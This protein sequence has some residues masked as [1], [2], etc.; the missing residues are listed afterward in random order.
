M[1]Y[2]MWM[3]EGVCQTCRR[4]ETRFKEHTRHLFL[5]QPENLAVAERIMGTGEHE[6]QQHLQNG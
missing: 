6:I 4:L 5:F 3:W 2:T 1:V